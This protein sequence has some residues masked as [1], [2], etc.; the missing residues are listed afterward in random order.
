MRRAISVYLQGA[1]GTY[2]EVEKQLC[3][4]AFLF[5]LGDRLEN[6]AANRLNFGP[7]HAVRHRR[8]ALH[9]LRQVV[10]RHADPELWRRY[11]AH[12]ARRN[13]GDLRDL[14]TTIGSWLPERGS[15]SENNPVRTALEE[16]WYWIH[17][18]NYRGLPLPLA[19]D[20]KEAVMRSV[21]VPALRE[22]LSTLIWRSLY[23]PA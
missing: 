9:T 15:L 10:L 7:I 3:V 14:Y 2:Q 22:F 11:M 4:E 17:Q 5:A 20:E 16:A 19:C 21:T 23:A 6:A 12:Q 13:T 18:S 8:N 1:A